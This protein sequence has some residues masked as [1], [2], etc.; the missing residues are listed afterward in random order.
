[1][2]RVRAFIPSNCASHNHNHTYTRL[3]LALLFDGVILPLL[4]LYWE[5]EEE[6]EEQRAWLWIDYIL[7]ETRSERE[8]EKRISINGT[9]IELP[10]TIVDVLYNAVVMRII[11]KKRKVT[12]CLSEQYM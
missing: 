9:Y 1:M 4:R 5:K 8:R 10:V 2:K 3:L 11:R 12:H 7:A 6:R